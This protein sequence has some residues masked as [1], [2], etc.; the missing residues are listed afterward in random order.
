MSLF[1]SVQGAFQDVIDNTALKKSQLKGKARE[2]THDT[3][4]VDVTIR[5]IGASGLPK[6][7]VVG[8]ADPYFRASIDGKLQYTSNVKENTLTPV[9]NETWHVKNVPTTAEIEVGVYDKDPG[10][11]DDAIG[12]F[13]GP[14]AAG[15][16]EFE[17]VSLVTK[18]N[19]GTF[20]MEIDLSDPTHGPEH[21][22]PYT[23]DGPVRF[24]RHFSPTVGLLTS[25]NDERLY[26]TWKISIKGVAMFFG[27]TVQGWNQKYPAAQLIFGPGP[28]SFALRVRRLGASSCSLFF[29]WSSFGHDR[30]VIQGEGEDLSTHILPSCC[31]HRQQAGND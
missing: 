13:H 11:H 1:S 24:T 6:V 4:Y 7:D 19:R 17:I 27:D 29:P 16:R 25:L 22:P 26:S 30:Q 21:C 18:R 5:F 9:W 12:Q 14:V 3:R 20:W 8:S 2:L 10:P 31:S 15:A 28:D 23:F